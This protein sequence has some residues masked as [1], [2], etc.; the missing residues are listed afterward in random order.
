MYKISK[1]SM[2][3]FFFFLNTISFAETKMT[4]NEVMQKSEK[5]YANCKSYTDTGYVK[6]VFMNKK[7][8]KINVSKLIFSTS[9]IRPNK[10]RFEYA[11]MRAGELQG[12]YI[13]WKNDEKVKTYWELMGEE[14]PKSLSMALAG[15]TGVSGGSAL[16]IPSLLIIT[17]CRN[18]LITRINNPTLLAEQKDENGIICFLIKGNNENIWIQKETFLI[19]KIEE[20]TEF[21]DFNTKSVTA[22]NPQVNIEI[23]ENNLKFKK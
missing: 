16:T 7:G 19:S 6:T 13:V 9:Y 22:Y 8:K 2:L 12:Q 17:V 18:P 23:P 3:L 10:F 11:E 4:A 21:D 5:V 1:L 15:A 20:Y 14:N